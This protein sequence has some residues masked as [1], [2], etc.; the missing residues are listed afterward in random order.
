MNADDLSA[1]NAV[2]RPSMYT[3]SSTVMNVAE[4]SSINTADH[5]AMTT[6][7]HATMKAD[8]PPLMYAAVLSVRKNLFPRS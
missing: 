3:E 2:G 5:A 8:H 7:N 6:E 1:L 4:S